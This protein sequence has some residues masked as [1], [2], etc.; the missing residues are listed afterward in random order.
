M[1]E[2]IRITEAEYQRIHP[3]F[4]GA[5]S[6]T[7]DHGAASATGDQG[8]ASATGYQGAASATGY[9]GAAISVGYK[10]RAMASDTG[11]IVLSTSRGWA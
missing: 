10:G 2:E 6:A 3:D 8:A 11:A 4:R 7:G 9:Q 5:A 1:P